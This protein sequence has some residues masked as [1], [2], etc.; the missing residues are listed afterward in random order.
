MVIKGDSEAELARIQSILNNM[1]EEKLDDLLQQNG[2][3]EYEEK[4]TPSIL[5]PELITELKRIDDFFDNLTLEEYERMMEE[6]GV[7]EIEESPGLVIPSDV[8]KALNRL[9]KQYN[10]L[11]EKE[12]N[13]IVD[14]FNNVL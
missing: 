14:K 12:V 9:A 4:N 8:E 7:Y 2:I 10:K 13:K 1:T 5:S 6:C 3:E 11:S